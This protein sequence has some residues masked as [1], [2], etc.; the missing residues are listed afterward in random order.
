[1]LKNYL[2]TLF[3]SFSRDL[4]YSLINLLGLATGLMVAFL[5]FIYIQD[6]LSYDKYVPDHERIYRLESHFEIKGKPDEFAITAL[7][8]GPALMDEYPD[9]ESYARIFNA[10]TTIFVRGEEKIQEDSIYI[11]DSTF[12]PLMSTKLLYGDAAKALAEPNT[13]AFSASMALKYFGRVNAIGE[14][15]KTI[16]NEVFRV[17]GVFPD[18]PWNTHV[19][20]NTLL[21]VATFARTVAREAFED[22]SSGA[23]WNVSVMTFVK[24][25][26]NTEMASVI[27]KFPA[28]YDKYMREIGDKIQGTFSLK[29][30]RLSR[31]HYHSGNLEWDQPTGNMSY[32]YILGAVGILM[33]IIAAI[34]YMNLSTARS[35]RRAREVG[36]RKVTGASK[37]VLVRQFLGESVILAVAAMLISVLMM[38]LILPVFNNLADK[39]FQPGMLLKP[40]IWGSILLITL[41]VGF[42]SGIYPAFYLSSFKPVKI[43][44]GTPTGQ[45]SGAGL[46]R[47]LVVFQ[48]FI[49]SGLIVASLA[50]TGQLRYMQKKDPGF[51]KDNLI[52]LSLNDS[53]V[54][55]NLEGFRQEL[56]RNPEIVATAA[57][58]GVPGNSLGKQVMRMEGLNGEMEEHAIN[59][60]VVGYEFPA[61][62]GVKLDTGRFYERSM[63]SDAAKAFVIN[64]AAVRAF[65]WQ[66]NP[67]GKRF[68]YGINLDGTARRDGEIVGVVKDFNYFSLHNPIEPL[69]FILDDNPESFYNLAIRIKPG[70]EQSSVNWIREVREKFN[71]YYP[72]DY[73]FL[74][75]K[76]NNQYA[77]EARMSRI[78]MIFTILILFV[79]ALG[80]L[81]LSAFITQQ[82]T[83]EIGIRKVLGSMPEQ[84]MLL[85][86]GEFMRWVLIANVFAIPVAWYFMDKWLQNFYYRIHITIVF[87]VISLGVSLVVAI[88][89]VTWQSWRASRLKPAISL[90]YE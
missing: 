48:F 59:Q 54:R 51:D 26:P 89:T 62:L 55:K 42:F 75:D 43:L 85:F 3:R 63:G 32:L 41:T 88:I 73:Y 74:S 22:R 30:T 7:P 57:T 13:I 47:S 8:L 23:F 10:G 4:F 56:E 5:I 78:F 77:A 29:A 24:M 66:D 65:N 86:L 60:M 70:T 83:R 28:F 79:A 46:R 76:L 14:S 49:S 52:I 81:G 36:M 31:I 84:I 72:L 39:N 87:F 40:V 34:N 17:T 12:L 35:A 67:L 38:V 27:G 64:E 58:N 18:L 45:I 33:L 68:Q 15:L 1:M 53:T 69:V 61:L 2:T 20:Y 25:K 19:R 6:E 80:L 82:K 44:K 90:K 11:A 71:P 37:T 50:V 16:N 9:I 21:S